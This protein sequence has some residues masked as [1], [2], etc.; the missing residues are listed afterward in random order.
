MCCRD[1][2]RRVSRDVVRRV[3]A[4]RDCHSLPCASEP[5]LSDLPINRGTA[6]LEKGVA[7]FTFVKRGLALLVVSASLGD[8]ESAEL[9]ARIR[10]F[11]ASSASRSRCASP[12]GSLAELTEE[13]RRPLDVGEYECDASGRRLGHSRDY[14]SPAPMPPSAARVFRDLDRTARALA[15][16]CGAPPRGC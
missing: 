13:P 6:S 11:V 8:G 16:A 9:V 2:N 4:R 5:R 15:A 12:A 3:S 14:D 7:E 1:S 10:R